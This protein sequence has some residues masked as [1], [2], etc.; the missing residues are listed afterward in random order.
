MS[1]TGTQQVDGVFTVSCRRLEDAEAEILRERTVAEEGVVISLQG[2]LDLSSA[3]IVEDEL[4]R[5]E[6]TQNL[7]LLDLRELLFMDSTGL[8]TV[9]EAH[10]RLAARGGSLVILQGPSQVRRLFELAGVDR[11]LELIDHLDSDGA[12]AG[13]PAAAHPGGRR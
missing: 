9:I 4:L 2:E 3:S 12:P 5:A 11:H 6:V 10:Y 7:I 8:R 13:Q 1:P